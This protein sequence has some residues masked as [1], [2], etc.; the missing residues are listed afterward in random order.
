MKPN[1]C[2]KS[3]RLKLLLEIAVSF[4]VALIASALLSKYLVNGYL[5]SHQENLSPDVYNFFALCVFTAAILIFIISFL[6]LANKH[7][8]Y[9]KYIAREV[10]LI[11]S[12]NLG[13]PLEVRGEDELAALC[14]N[15]NTM[16][17]ELKDRFEYERNLEN[18][19]AELITNVSHDL[20][21]PLTAIIGYL[22]LLKNEKTAGEGER[23]E[24]LN[25]TYNL[26]MQ[27][28]H[29]IDE[30]FE[31]TKLSGS[32]GIMEMEEVDIGAVLNQ[33]VG[34]YTPIMESKGL[35]IVPEIPNEPLQVRIDIEKMVRVFD[36]ILSNAEKYSLNPSEIQIQAKKAGESVLISFSNKGEHL[37]EE[38]LSKIFDRFYRA[39]P[40]RSATSQGSGLGL[41]ISKKIVEL[42]HGDI[43]AE[44]KGDTVTFFVKLKLEQHK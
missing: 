22:D 6:L 21:T 17:K 2:L 38:N 1:I 34:E 12:R 10:K 31:Y 16:S 4:I 18:T 35:K 33:I 5:E 29:L 20:R 32:E 14:M 3:L 9:I 30:L 42:H 43:W 27:L 28:K 8:R 40:S 24:Y 37:S 41:A 7:I 25:S 23:K 36:N 39:D 13:E 15:I 11:A 26:S 44:S 19:K